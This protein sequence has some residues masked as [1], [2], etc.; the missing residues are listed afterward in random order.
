[1]IIP[2]KIQKGDTIGVV[3]PSGPIIGKNIEELENAK[4]IVEESRIQ[5]IIC[6]KYI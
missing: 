3:A 2:K 4:K 5:R 1:M 6:K